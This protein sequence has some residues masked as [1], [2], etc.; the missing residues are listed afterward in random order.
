MEPVVNAEFNLEDYKITR[1]LLIAPEKDEPGV[2]IAFN[3][4]GEYNE[5]S[6]IFKLTFDFIA[7]FG[8][9]EKD[10]K[11]NIFEATL[12][13]N[14]KFQFPLEFDRIPDFFYVNSIAIVFPHL[15][16][17]VSTVTSLANAKRIILPL[18]NLTNLETVLKENTVLQQ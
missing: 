10:D 8:D 16:A 11:E 15:R 18:L 6:G 1:F 9:P 14:F 5:A 17:F 4:S 12:V 7:F 13:S 3:P 2:H